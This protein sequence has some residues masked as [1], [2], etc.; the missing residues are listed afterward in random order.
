MIGLEW[1]N[2]ELRRANEML[3]AAEAFL[4]AGARPAPSR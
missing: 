4:R 2:L 3:K 1:E